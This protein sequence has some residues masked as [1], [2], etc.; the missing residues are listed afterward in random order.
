MLASPRRSRPISSKISQKYCSQ[1]TFEEND[2]RDP[3]N[4]PKWLKWAI[5]I[6]ASMFTLL[7]SANGATYTLGFDTMTVDLNCTT[8]QAT[9]GVAMYCLGFGI[10]PLFSASF[11]EEFGRRP[12]YVVSSVGFMLMHIMAA[13]SQNVSTVIVA[14]F[15]S[16]AFGSTGST[17]VGGSIADIWRP[18]E[19]GTPMS[20]FTLTAISGVAVGPVAAGWIDMDP[21]LGWRW[22]QW[23][24]AIAAGLLCFGI[25]IFM[26]ETRGSIILTRLA[27]KTRKETGDT[28]YRARAEDETA[29]LKTLIWISSTRP[30]Y[31]LISEPIVAACS[32]WIGFAWGILYCMIE[33]IG[34]VFRDLHGFNTGEMGT[35]F[36]AV[37]VGVIFGFASTLHQERLYQKYVK[38]RGSEARL[39]WACAAGIMFPVGMF[40]YAWTTFP[41]VPWIALCIGIAIV[42]WA[43]YI[44]Y[45][46]V[47]VYLADIYGPFAS[48]SLAGQSLCRNLMGMAFPLFTN[49]MFAAMTYKWANTLFGCLAALMAPIP[50]IL[51]FYGPKIREYSKFA[52]QAMHN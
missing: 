6:T 32:L 8:F 38:T 34:S 37:L 19:R 26:K 44:M 52:R 50:F 5:T 35:A 29:S 33:S 20:I 49:Q 28:R 12:L 16:G 39:Y 25:W 31:L 9:I 42:I 46:A 4:F 3:I 21:R 15:L 40:I 27:K 41:Y 2:P 51:L 47:F 45:M 43:I 48:S 18:Y 23:I 1:V 10:V 36:L 17:M 30:F 11:S 24:H 7:A 22:I 14:R 13:L